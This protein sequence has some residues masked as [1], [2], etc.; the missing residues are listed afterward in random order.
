MGVSFP[1]LE[2]KDVL[3]KIDESVRQIEQIIGKGHVPSYPLYILTLLQAFSSQQAIQNP[4]YSIHGFYYE[5]LINTSLSKSIKDADNIGVYNNLLS[6][7]AYYFFIN[8]KTEIT[9]REF[10]LIIDEFKKFIDVEEYKFTAENVLQVLADSKMINIDS[11]IYFYPKYIYY[12]FVAKYLAN[13]LNSYSEEKSDKVKDIVSKLAKRV[14]QEEFSSIII[15]LTHLS[16]DKYVINELLNNASNIFAGLS[17]T[18]LEQDVSK[19]NDL[20]DHLPDQVL[21]LM[22]VEEA[23]DEQLEFEE[24]QSL[25]E[26]EL[27]NEDETNC[28]YDEDYEDIDLLEQLTLSM[29]TIEILGQI[30]KKYWGELDGDLKIKLA[31]ETYFLGLRTMTFVRSIILDNQEGIIKLLKASV[32][33]KMLRD[34]HLV[35]NYDIKEYVKSNAN[36]YL[37]KLAFLSIYGIIKRV[38][39][40]IGSKKIA[41]T[42]AKLIENNPYNSVKLIDISIKL[43]YRYAFP[44]NELD[45]TDYITSNRLSYLIKQNLIT[46]YLYIYETNHSKK[47]KIANKYKIKIKDQLVIDKTSRVKRKTRKK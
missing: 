44:W 46:H 8:R 18:K 15:F 25:I 16:K 28:H 41:N 7:I 31:T 20:I 33:K 3:E 10:D 17:I 6:H 22:S 39:N 19:I 27:E 37:F 29:N 45:D 42:L 24:E 35:T 13:N 40:S 11:S 47:V 34:K 30:T 36:Q 14:Y 43:D 38:S 1:E 2:K 9:K 12:F 5:L 21:K 26:R 23:R 4:T 32:E